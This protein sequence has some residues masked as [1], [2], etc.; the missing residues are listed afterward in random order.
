MKNF[1]HEPWAGGGVLGITVYLLPHIRTMDITTH[2]CRN[3]V[4][5]ITPHTLSIELHMTGE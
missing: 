3:K 2:D 4:A 5:V 1:T